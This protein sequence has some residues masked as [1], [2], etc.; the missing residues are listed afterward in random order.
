MDRNRETPPGLQAIFDANE[1]SARR[2]EALVS[3]KG[4]AG[5][6]GK[7]KPES[8]ERKECDICGGGVG[9]CRH[10]GFGREAKKSSQR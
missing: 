9:G 5:R 10:C 3:G 7:G 8:P 4:K 1:E 6:G 2:A